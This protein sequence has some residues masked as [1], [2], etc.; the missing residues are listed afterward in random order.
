[1]NLFLYYTDRSVNISLNQDDAKN[2]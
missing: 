2:K 1:M